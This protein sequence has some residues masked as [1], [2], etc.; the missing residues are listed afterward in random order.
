M[1]II[2]ALDELKDG[3]AGLG[4]CAEGFSIEQF[5]F[6][7]GKEALTQSVVEAV[8][9]RAHRRAQVGIPAAMAEGQGGILTALIG[10]MDDA[11]R[12][13]LADGHGQGLEHQLGAQMV[14]QGP[15][16]H[17]AA[18]GVDNDGQVQPASP[19]GD[20]GDIGHPQAVRPLG[21]EIALHQI[22]RR[23]GIRLAARGAWAFPPANTLQVS[24]LHQASHPLT[25]HL[26][27]LDQ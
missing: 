16:D 8:A 27:A 24:R 4:L 18:P 3:Q 14:G 7:G 22:R 15:T 13:P 10:V 9:D 20:V 23:P 5:T 12:A 17:A 1:G 11:F 21:A 6:Q 19:S 2:P 26:P 25:P